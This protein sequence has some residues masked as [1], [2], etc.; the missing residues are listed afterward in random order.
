MAWTTKWLCYYKEIVFIALNK[1]NKNDIKLIPGWMKQ[2]LLRP[3][4]Q[5]PIGLFLLCIFFISKST[6]IFNCFFTAWWRLWIYTSY[7]WL[8]SHPIHPGICYCINLPGTWSSRWA[9]DHCGMNEPSNSIYL[10]VNIY[11]LLLNSKSKLST[12]AL[13]H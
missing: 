10:A 8:P 5:L 9:T 1:S 12:F 7:L 4:V 13:R 11:P 2:F 6:D 3:C